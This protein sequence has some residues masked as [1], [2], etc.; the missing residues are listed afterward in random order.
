MAEGDNAPLISSTLEGAETA[1]HRGRAGS[2]VVVLLLGAAA[3][4]GLVFL[5]S[6]DDQAR[7]YGEIGKK[8]NG[9][10]RAH[11]MQFWGCALPG[12]NLA[13]VRSNVVLMAQVGGRAME[14]GRNYGVHVRDKCMPMLSEIGPQLDM[15]IVPDDVRAD[16]TAMQKANGELRSAF[17][18]FI[19][20][21]DDPELEYDEARAKPQLSAIAR[22]FYEFK[23]AHGA[24]NAK[25]KAKLK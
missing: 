5:V 8:V 23:K 19:T 3:V 10:E 1:M 18:G 24:F 2:L 16:V 12:E 6:G 22:A 11:F 7:V 15:L 13:D 17:S 4:A 25:I 14:R 20:Y 21:L 9:L